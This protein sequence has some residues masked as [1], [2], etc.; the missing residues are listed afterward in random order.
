M[1]ENKTFENILSEMLSYVSDRNPE[2]DTRVGSIIYTA[3]AP[4]ALE[5]ETAYREMSMIVD[6]TFIDTASKEYL[7]RLGQQLGLPIREATYGHFKGEFN[8]DVPIGSRFNLDKFNYTVV[9]KLSEPIEGYTYYT[10]DLICETAG[11]APNERRGGLTPISYVENLSRAQLIDVIAYGE[12]EEETETYR[13]R[14]QVHV[15]EPPV[16]GNVAQYKEWLDNYDGVGKYRITPGWDGVNTVKLTI[17][18]SNDGEASSELVA[19]VQEYFDPD[20]EGMGNGVAPIGATVHV[21]TASE[22]P[23][24]VECTMSLKDGY[25]EPVGVEDAVE[26][27]IRSMV[28]TESEIK[29]LPILI[30]IYKAASVQ[31]VK[32]IAIKA[33]GEEINPLEDLATSIELDEDEIP[34]IDFTNC[35]WSVQ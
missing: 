30:A 3:L 13:Y 31:E 33:N 17:L 26:E 6:E 11:E 16:N 18:D 4:I 15:N 12:E 28:F 24:A 35:V 7:A 29:G 5:L 23:V 10:F 22:I 14:L 20:V 34:V 2:L 19:Q 1:F 8:V 25:T 32:S 27:C 21:F 9:E